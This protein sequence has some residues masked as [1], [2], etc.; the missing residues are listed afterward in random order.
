MFKE[1]TQDCKEFFIYLN[2]WIFYKRQSI[3]ME[4]SIRLADVKQKA[5]NKQYHILLLSLPKCEKL[6]SVNRDDIIRMKR[7]KWLPKNTSI[8]DLLHSES[9]FY[10]T[11][12]NRNNKSSA[13]ERKA[14]KAKYLK[15]SKRYLKR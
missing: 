13:T 5:F 8:F 12:L 4:L 9:T 3:K 7:K 10:S 6:V 2:N 1:I 11:P 15:Y 14:A